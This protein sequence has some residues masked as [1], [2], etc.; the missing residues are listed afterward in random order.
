MDHLVS[1]RQLDEDRSH[2]VAKAPA[3]QTVEWDAEIINEIP[4]V[5]IAWKTRNDADVVSAGSV[6][7]KPAPTGG[8]D[9]RVR[10]RYHPPAGKSG[11]AVAWMFG[12]EP[13]QTVHEDL[14]RFKHLME[15][16]EA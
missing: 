14:R 10:L 6:N 13:S 5:L 8:T 4:D 7:F 1:V 16:R 12:E 11:S 2:W 9:V 3:G 15:A